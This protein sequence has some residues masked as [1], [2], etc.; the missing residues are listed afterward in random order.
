M[1]SLKMIDKKFGQRR[2]FDDFSM[3]FQPGKTY[4]LIGRSGSG[5][6][7][8]LNMIGKLEPY[9]SG[10]IMIGDKPLQQIKSEEYF[11]DY[12]GYLFQNLGLLDNES[13]EANLELGLVGQ[14]IGKDEKKALFKQVLKEVGLSYLDLDSLIYTLSGGESQRI[15]MAKLILKKPK[16][17]LAD[18]PTGNLDPETGNQIVELLHSI[19]Q[20]ETAVIMSTHNYSIVQNYPA[21]IV[22]CENMALIDFYQDFLT[23]DKDNQNSLKLN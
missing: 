9:D 20:K 19:S 17:L 8:L 15:S 7:T 16:I 22:K 3:D 12:M 10:E 4:A 11:R 14:K 5:K 6:T 23:V 21:K 1:I 18:E 2:I 13:I